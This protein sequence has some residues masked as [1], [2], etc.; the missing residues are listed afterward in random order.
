MSK[1]TKVTKAEE[2]VAKIDVILKENNLIVVPVLNIIQGQVR[3]TVE[4][5]D[6]PKEDMGLD[7]TKK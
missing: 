6:K 2:A 7:P 1:E 3:H 4:I 5:V